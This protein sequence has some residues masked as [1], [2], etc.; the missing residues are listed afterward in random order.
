MFLDSKIYISNLVFKRKPIIEVLQFNVHNLGN[1]TYR[2]DW[3]DAVLKRWDEEQENFMAKIFEPL[4]LKFFLGDDDETLSTFSMDW[5]DDV[6]EETIYHFFFPFS[7]GNR[8]IAARTT[9]VNFSG[10]HVESTVD[11]WMDSPP[12][13]A[14]LL[15]SSIRGGN[16]SPC[17]I[18]YR[19]CSFVLGG[20]HSVENRGGRLL[21]GCALE[22]SA[23]NYKV[24]GAENADGKIYDHGINLF[25]SEKFTGGAIAGFLIR[26]GGGKSED[27]D[28]W[29]KFASCGAL[30][31][32]GYGRTISPAAACELHCKFIWN[33]QDSSSAETVIG[34]KTRFAAVDSLRG[35]LNFRYHRQDVAEK[36][37]HFFA[38]IAWEHEFDGG[39]ENAFDGGQIQDNGNGKRDCG[40]FEAGAAMKISQLWTL[41][42]NL[43]GSIGARKGIAGDLTF[44]RSF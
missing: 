37:P 38:G 30:A 43:R 28:Y 34:T 5:L 33:H 24:D 9:A 25:C 32:V 40:L 26:Q 14:F 29:G 19:G 31:T 4:F 41:S 36:V 15:F 1:I 35:R 11:G 21:V 44:H 6:S 20:M 39:I 42:G 16:L 12:T 2:Y 18:D 13:P 27:D 23:G 8:G 22:S 10:D 7:N 3:G 17:S